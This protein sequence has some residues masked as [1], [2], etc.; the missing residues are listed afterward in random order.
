MNEQHATMEVPEWS[1][2]ICAAMVAGGYS[3]K[4]FEA[5]DVVRIFKEEMNDSL[6][7]LEV[8]TA[9][10]DAVSEGFMVVNRLGQYRLTTSGT[11][12]GTYILRDMDTGLD[13]LGIQNM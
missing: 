1:A 5:D 10:Q 13:D 9:L 6:S 7:T 2:K 4:T 11:E 12:I 8:W 3:Q